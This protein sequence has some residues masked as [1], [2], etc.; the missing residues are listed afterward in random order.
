MP[1]LHITYEERFWNKHLETWHN[2]LDKFDGVEFCLP[3]H[4]LSEKFYTD[5]FIEILSRG[6]TLRFHLPHHIETESLSTQISDLNALS[7]H[8]YSLYYDAIVAA[9]TQASEKNIEVIHHPLDLGYAQTMTLLKKMQFDYRQLGLMPILEP[10]D[11]VHIC[12]DELYS[13]A[14]QWMRETNQ[15][16]FC[17]DI[18]YL[19]KL[20]LISTT[21]DYRLLSYAQVIHLHNVVSAHGPVVDL[22][23][24][25]SAWFRATTKQN[26]CVCLEILERGCESMRISYLEAIDQTLNFI[27]QQN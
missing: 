24:E 4:A 12:Y 7:M 25:L 19:N 15:K 2:Y 1:I 5:R 6:K 11:S 27:A 14:H 16:L 22:P 10:T 20:N 21:G 17:L 3:R 8:T 18:H 23:D 13:M 9:I 26:L